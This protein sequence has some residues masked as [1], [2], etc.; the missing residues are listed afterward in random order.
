[1]QKELPAAALELIPEETRWTLANI[2]R[3]SAAKWNEWSAE[4]CDAGMSAQFAKQAAEAL[5]FAEQLENC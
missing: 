2:C 4:L 3:S 5:A 1:M